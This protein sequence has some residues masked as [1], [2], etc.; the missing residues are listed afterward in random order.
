[1]LS[2]LPLTFCWHSPLAKPN[3]KLEIQGPID[4]VHTYQ[5]PEWMEKR[6]EQ[7]WRRVEDTHPATFPQPVSFPHHLYHPYLS[8]SN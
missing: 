2:S 8:K 7:A 4:A 1:M 5:L 3:W 6:G